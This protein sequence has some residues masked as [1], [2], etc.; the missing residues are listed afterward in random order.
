MVKTHNSQVVKENEAA[1]Q[2]YF[3]LSNIALLPA[4]M[5]TLVVL[6]SGHEGV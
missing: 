2:I 1:I 3:F 5:A 6:C 4:M